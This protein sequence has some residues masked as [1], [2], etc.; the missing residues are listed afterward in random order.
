MRSGSRWLFCFLFAFAALLPAADSFHFVLLGDRTG[1]AQPGVYERVWAEATR[2]DP[3]FVVSVGDTIQGFNDAT[4]EAEW[5]QVDQILAPFRKFSLY[6]TAGNHDIWSEKSATL[7]REHAGHPPHYSFD[8]G[9]A[10]FTILDNSRSD[11]L[12]KDEIAFLEEDLKGHAAQPLK[13]IVSHRPS[14]IFGAAA[15][16]PDFP[17]HQLARKY[18]VQYVVAGHV[19]EMLHYRLQGIDYVS[20]PS[21]GGHLRASG[22]YQDGWFFGF[23]EVNVRNNNADFQIHELRGRVSGLGEWGPTGLR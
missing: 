3:A 12:Q 18:G 9:P 19:H 22:K 10:H 8:Y 15:G 1:E 5:E 6:L 11:D 21:S 23:I 14:W 16:N 13:F 20:L 2:D 7:F 4:A 17:L